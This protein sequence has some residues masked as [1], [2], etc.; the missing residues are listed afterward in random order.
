MLTLPD[1]NITNKWILDQ[2]GTKN[3]VDPN[4]P[5]AFLVEKERQANGKIEDVTTIFLTNKECPFRCLMCDLWKN[6]TDDTI[7]V[8]AI[9]KQIEFALKNLPSTK[10]IKLYNSGN[11]FDSTAIPLKDHNA[12]ASL[13]HGFETVL[14]ENHPK[15]TDRRILEFRDKLNTDLQL[16]IGLE[17]THP[18]VLPKLN[19][20]M[21]LMD[22]S[23]SV[24]MLK[25]HD[26]LCR[27][28]ILLRPPFLSEE[29]GVEWAKKSIDFAFDCGVECCA[30]IPTRSGN[31][32]LNILETNGLFHSPNLASL[33]HV[34]EYGI[35]LDKGRVF[36]DLW[37]LEHF[38]ECT[39]CLDQRKVRM[40]EMNLKQEILDPIFCSCSD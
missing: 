18:E 34:Q 6:T 3:A 39:D 20:Q 4:K 33:E 14:V 15:L 1:F 10:H 31:G 12:I 22:F 38:S 11:F 29:E 21:S 24:N 25:T 17:T 7:D 40:D 8:G 9:P 13:L 36:A 16:A 26:I 2:R 5:Y 27:A 37:D 35:S 32:A 19:K 28:F 23:K 30:V